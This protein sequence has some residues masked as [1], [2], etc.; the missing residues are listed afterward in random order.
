MGLCPGCLR[1]P[2]AKPGDVSTSVS[3][4]SDRISNFNFANLIM[5]EYFLA[6]VGPMITNIRPRNLDCTSSNKAAPYAFLCPSLQLWL[7]SCTLEFPLLL[8]QSNGY[9]ILLN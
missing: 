1:T 6:P 4:I 8:L 5:F 9:R 3:E 7:P 2:V